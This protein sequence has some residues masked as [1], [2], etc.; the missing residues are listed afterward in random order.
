VKKYEWKHGIMGKKG[1]KKV[2]TDIGGK[3]RRKG[4]EARGKTMKTILFSS[5]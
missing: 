3:E 5:L 4:T 1:A 2:G